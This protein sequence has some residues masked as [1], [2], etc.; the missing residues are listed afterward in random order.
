MWWFGTCKNT[1][2]TSNSSVCGKP[3]TMRCGRKR[4]AGTSKRRRC[5]GRSG[6]AFH[7]RSNRLIP[8]R[9]Q[10]LAQRYKCLKK[11]PPKADGFITRVANTFAISRIRQLFRIKM[12][13]RSPALGAGRRRKSRECKC[14]PIMQP[15][16]Q[17]TRAQ[18]KNTLHVA[19][20]AWAT[21]PKPRCKRKLR[22]C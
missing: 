6:R 17:A 19:K 11:P 22:F 4:K 3:G 7:R 12:F 15:T 13:G 14:T 2:H 18:V 10:G 5:K 20:A 1:A 8:S 21:Q 16:A 9:K